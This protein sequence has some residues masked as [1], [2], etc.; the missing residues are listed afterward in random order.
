LVPE[1]VK[2]VSYDKAR[3]MLR[4][5]IVEYKKNGYNRIV[6]SKLRIVNF[7]HPMIK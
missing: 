6:R 7:N 2:P 4:K 5:T 1:F 3:Q